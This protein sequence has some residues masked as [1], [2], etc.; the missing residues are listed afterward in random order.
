MIIAR[1]DV[2]R[3]KF[4]AEDGKP[5]GI[6]EPAATI[7][8]EI[9]DGDSGQAQ[10]A[11]YQTTERALEKSRRAFDLARDLPI[12]ATLFRIAAAESLLVV[13][14]HHTVAD[15]PSI[16]IIV[17]ELAAIYGA[18]RDGMT[19]KLAELELRY[20]DFVGWQRDLSKEVEERCLFYWKYQ[21][22]GEIPALQLPSTQLRPAVHR[23]TPSWI[24]FFFDEDLSRQI[25][26]LGERANVTPF[27]VLLSVFK[28]TLL[29][30]SRQDEIVV[31]I[32]EAYRN[33]RETQEVI[34]PFANLLAIRSRLAGNLSFRA[35]LARVTRTIEQARKHAALPFDRLVQT[36]NPKKDMSRNPLFDV[37]F[38]FDD[39]EVLPLKLADVEA[40]RI[41]LNLGFGKYDIHLSIQ[42]KGE[43][44]VGGF[45][46][47]SD[48]YASWIAHQMVSHFKAIANAVAANPEQAIED[49]RFLSA[50]EERQQLATWNST[51]VV[52]PIDATIHQLFAEQVRRCPDKIAVVCKGTQLSYGELN[53]RSNQLAHL[54]RREGVG[55]DSLVALCL[56]K[57]S[58][59]IV[60][61]LAVLKAGA[62]YLPLDIE[63][64]EGRLHGIL[65]DARV[66]HAVTTI[67]IRDDVLK[68]VPSVVFLDSDRERIMHQPK[69]TPEAPADPANLAYCMYTS[70][71]TGE[72]KGV[73]VEHRNVV[74]LVMNANRRFAF[75]DNDVWT[76]FHSYCFDFSVWE[77][78]GALLH[79]GKLVV[80]PKETAKEPFLF[81]RLLIEEEVTVLNQTPS[82]FKGVMGEALRASKPT[83][84]LRYV[85]L[86]GEALRPAQFTEWKAAYPD[87]KLVNM[88]GIT[89][90]T[91][92]ASFKELTA[93]DMTQDASNIG[94]PLPG[95]TIYILD[96]K[97]RL[98]PVGVPGEVCVG[99]SGVSRGYLR[100]DDLT[101]QKFLR[102]PYNPA[103]RIYC[104]GD[105][106]KYLPNGDV[107]YLGRKDEQVQIRGFRVEL[108]EVKAALLRHPAV[109]EAAVIATNSGGTADQIVA[110]IVTRSETNA[111]ALRNFLQAV[112]PPY[113]IP[114]GFVILDALPV[115]GNGKLDIKA[116][117]PF[118][119]A[120]ANLNGSFAPPRNTIEEV[121]RDIWAELLKVGTIGVHDSFFELGG[122]SLMAAELMFRVR[123]LFQL[124]LPLQSLFETPTVAGLALK[125]A[126]KRRTSVPLEDFPSAVPASEQRY[127]PFPLT[128]VQQAYWIGRTD[129][130]ELGGVASHGY[131]ELECLNVDL[132]RVLIARGSG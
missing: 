88:Y 60:A 52:Y 34:G 114:S 123:Q 100:R 56:D 47:N 67:T 16:G 15:A 109:T 125:I 73:L 81:L 83:L 40:N 99:G 43:E 27:A 5:L 12:S 54:L 3:T 120:C 7:E 127:L 51:E 1:H 80:V 131:L 70:G 55:A 98:L 61:I 116:L 24:R 115:T 82:A 29:R 101:R 89:E 45:L 86:G 124:E 62:A 78:F 21:L 96:A 53:E 28:V 59:L 48:L 102:N 84:F 44:W 119:A 19:P 105:I 20:T 4:A 22:G 91:V 106:A 11:I 85:I 76:L 97:Q 13:I 107:L 18:L 112:L 71:S 42:R 26:T 64:P 69:T 9:T 74:Q 104:S 30:Y 32:S 63:D 130:F 93:N 94:R 79:G 50:S 111:L 66:S 8:L 33:Q 58:W 72:P 92:H 95:T 6:V 41:D 23:F 103:E 17:K 110:Y 49:I 132:E 39:C 75:G 113:M 87:T 14:V 77:I 108:Q 31:G 129:S 117:P 57:S 121:L 35:V 10:S 2:L 37:F 126:E 65:R 36:L 128:D 68:D 118:K 90:T 122:H 38:H 25:R 46:Y